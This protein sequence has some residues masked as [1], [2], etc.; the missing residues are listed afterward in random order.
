MLKIK[1]KFFGFLFPQ[2]TFF[3]E[4]YIWEGRLGNCLKASTA[5]STAAYNM[6]AKSEKINK[7]QH[8]LVI[9]N[10][11]TPIGNFPISIRRQFGSLVRQ[12]QQH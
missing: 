12:R 4:L 5:T 10:P 8:L 3:W 1:R 11:T 7:I 6:Y 9:I 2:V